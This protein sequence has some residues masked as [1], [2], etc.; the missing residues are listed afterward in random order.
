MSGCFQNI[1]ANDLS[2]RK[3]LLKKVNSEKLILNIKKLSPN[4]SIPATILKTMCRCLPSVLKKSYN[5]DFFR[6]VLAK[7]I[8]KKQK[9]FQYI[10]S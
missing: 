8:G 5:E 6:L 9:L 2:F 1:K 4:S 7:P 3:V 10:K